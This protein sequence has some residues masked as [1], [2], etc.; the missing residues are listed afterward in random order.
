MWFSLKTKAGDVCFL[1]GNNGFMV[2]QKHVKE[3]TP[4]LTKHMP[5][6]SK[7]T[8]ICLI[9]SFGCWIHVWHVPH[10]G[11]WSVSVCQAMCIMDFP[12][13]CLVLFPTSRCCLRPECE[14]L[15]SESQLC[16]SGSD[17][18]V[19]VWLFIYFWPWQHRHSRESTCGVPEA[20]EAENTCLQLFRSIPFATPIQHF[21]F[22]FGQLGCNVPIYIYI[23]YLP[24]SISIFVIFTPSFQPVGNCK[25]YPSVGVRVWSYNPRKYI[26]FH[27]HIHHEAIGHWDIQ[28][29]NWSAN[30]SPSGGVPWNSRDGSHLCTLVFSR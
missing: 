4:D 23:S 16:E 2:F 6:S 21:F 26:F 10:L 11:M 15:E 30:S 25:M 18:F 8:P 9:C 29:I 7:H 5:S 17:R 12:F 13:A 19:F 24:I 14:R 28:P 27:H 1:E 20:L 22:C 3:Y